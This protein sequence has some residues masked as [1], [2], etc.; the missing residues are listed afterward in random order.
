MRVRDDRQTFLGSWFR[1]VLAGEP[2]LVFGDGEQRRDFTYVDDA[3][4]A[5]LA[6][7]SREEARGQVFNLGGSEA[8]SLRELAGLVV[9]ANGGGEWRLVP[10]PEER[11]VIDI[12]D[13]FADFA[14]I[15]AALGWQPRV[16]LRE[17]LERSLAFYREHGGAYWS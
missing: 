1:A 11:K 6:A 12:G 3:V 7:A 9:E 17:G 8:V 10:F 15:S 5:F 4:A 16:G 13:Y 14:K 2:L